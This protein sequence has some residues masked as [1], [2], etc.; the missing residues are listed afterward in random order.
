MMSAHKIKVYLWLLCIQL[1]SVVL[2]Q[3]KVT[4]EQI[5]LVSDVDAALPGPVGQ[6]F[7]SDA[8]LFHLN[9]STEQAA[10]S[11][12]LGQLDNAGIDAFHQVGDGCGDALYS[13][14]NTAMVAGVAM[15]PADVFT[16]AGV[17]VLNASAVGIP[18]GVN[19][20]AVSRAISNCDLVVSVDG[21]VEL[22]GSV[23]KT[24]DLIRWSASNG[25][26][27]Y[28][29]TG[30]N[31]HIDALHIL[32]DNQLLLSVKKTISV[33]NNQVN[34]EAIIEWSGGSY[35]L[36]PFNPAAVD[37]SWGSADL[38]ALWVQATADDDLIFRNGFE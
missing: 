12:D 28:Q 21:V 14:D 35:Q 15:H 33:D 22:N 34:D 7:G 18:S 38:V 36:F 10:V 20:T 5:S 11:L 6:V 30:L 8:H 29:A 9:T 13:L 1:C 27:L 4:I 2:A 26:T 19:V 37:D 3:G 24:D 25:F 16:A 32:D 23:F 31:T 17:K